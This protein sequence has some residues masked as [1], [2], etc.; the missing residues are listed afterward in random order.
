M[1][2]ENRTYAIPIAVIV[3]ILTGVLL[4]TIGDALIPFVAAL[5]LANIFL[6]L[7]DA[8]RKKKIPT[9]FSILLVLV[10]VACIFAGIAIVVS[11]SINSAAEILPKYGQKWDTVYKPGLADMLG[12]IS[13]TLREKVMAFNVSSSLESLPIGEGLSSI[14]TSLMSLISSFA[15]ILL[16]MLFILAG[17]G[18]FRS[19]LHR[20]FSSSHSL[21]LTEMFSDIQSRTRSYTAMMLLIN[22]LSG[23]NLALVSA[24]FGVDLAILWG[25]LTF[26][27]MLIPSVGSILAAILPITVA[28]LQFDTIGTPI[29]YSVIL[30]VSQLLIGSVL[31]PKIMGN[32]LNLSPL[33]ILVGLLFWGWVWGPWGMVLSV[34]ITSTLVIIFENIPSLQPLAILMSSDISKAKI[35]IWKKKQQA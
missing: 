22:I 9:V 34:P 21:R 28:F 12:S 20:A 10:L 19:K 29:I 18:Q 5:F 4:H 32:N 26:L 1:E 27:L 30:L 35:R 6:P 3:V 16:F 14:T 23:I 8:F 13:P 17:S 25:F 33:L 31:S 7:V 24:L 2:S 15:L 11:I